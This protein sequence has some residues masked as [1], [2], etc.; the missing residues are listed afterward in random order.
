MLVDESQV[1]DEE[2]H[3]RLMTLSKSS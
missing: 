2:E 3:V 1:V